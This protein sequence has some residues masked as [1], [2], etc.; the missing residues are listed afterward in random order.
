MNFYKQHYPLLS[1]ALFVIIILVAHVIARDGYRWTQHTI[2]HL[3]SQEYANAWLMRLGFVLFGA[4]LLIG[5]FS[6]QWSVRT[7]PIAIYAFAILMSGIFCAEPFGQ[8]VA[9]NVHEA[10]WHSIFA[11]LAGVAFSIGILLQIWFADTNQAKLIHGLFFVVVIL[12]SALFGLLNTHVGIVQ[13]ILYMVSLV[14]LSFYFEP[15]A[16]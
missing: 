11:Q 6:N 9:Y 4:M 3:A 8:A 15:S 14:W 2:S 7:L 13:R 1:T 12:I 16:N 5:V 10:R